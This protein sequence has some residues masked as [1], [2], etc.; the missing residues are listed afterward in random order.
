MTCADQPATVC[1]AKLSAP[2]GCALSPACRR[3]L[4]RT[5]RSRRAKKCSGGCNG[6]WMTA[7]ANTPKK[8]TAASGTAPKRRPGRPAKNR[9]QSDAAT[10]TVQPLPITGAE[11]TDRVL[12]MVRQGCDSGQVIDLLRGLAWSYGMLSVR[13]SALLQIPP[14]DFDRLAASIWD[15]Y[16]RGQVD[17]SEGLI[18]HGAKKEQAA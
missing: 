11:V 13:L 10:V 9:P 17:M 6:G 2:K 5:R 16:E 14:S 18:Q 4:T 15:E 7:T 12:S 1:A 8:P 3:T